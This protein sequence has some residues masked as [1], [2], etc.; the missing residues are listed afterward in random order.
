MCREGVLRQIKDLSKTVNSN[1][2]E[3]VY[4]NLDNRLTLNYVSNRPPQ[5][6]DLNFFTTLYFKENKLAVVHAYYIFSDSGKAVRTYRYFDKTLSQDFG[7]GRDSAEFIQTNCENEDMIITLILEPG[8]VNTLRV[9][10][11]HKLF[12]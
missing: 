9:S 2:P 4:T 6:P 11:K 8:D 7:R 3:S 12:Y 10:V 1:D 5:N